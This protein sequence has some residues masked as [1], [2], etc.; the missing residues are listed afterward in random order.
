MSKSAMLV[1]TNCPAD[2]E[3]EFNTW[4]DTIHVPDIIA[5][6]G[7]TAGRRYKLSGPGPKMQTRDGSTAVA[8]YLAIY[9]MEDEDT[10]AAMQRLGKA[11]GDLAQRGRMFEGLEVVGSATYVA[12]G[13][14]QK[15]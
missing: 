9:E 15:A 5:T 8:Q 14:K 2:K 10:A 6:E 3:A 12:L 13:D 1:F 7:F 4:Y 11:V